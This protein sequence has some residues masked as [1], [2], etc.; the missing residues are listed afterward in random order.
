MLDQE[1]IMEEQLDQLL[2]RAPHMAAADGTVADVVWLR[3]RRV[4]ESILDQE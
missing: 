3:Y 2:D 1:Q 4:Q